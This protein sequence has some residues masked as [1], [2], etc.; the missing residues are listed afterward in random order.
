MAKYVEEGR[1]GF[2]SLRLTLKAFKMKASWS[3]LESNSM[4]YMLVRNGYLNGKSQG[5]PLLTTQLL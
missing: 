3:I 5:H 1:I 2:R 4:W